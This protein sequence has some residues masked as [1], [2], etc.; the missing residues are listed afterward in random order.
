M[1]GGSESAG[2][3]EGAGVKECVD[4][5]A[6]DVESAGEFTHCGCVMSC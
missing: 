4:W 2:C 6:A 5:V 3:G 1:E